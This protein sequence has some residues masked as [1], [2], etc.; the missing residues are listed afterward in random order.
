M[1][2]LVYSFSFDSLVNPPQMAMHCANA[3]KPLKTDGA[4]V[5][6]QAQVDVLMVLEIFCCSKSFAT[7]LALERPL[8]IACVFLVVVPFIF[9]F[10]AKPSAFLTLHIVMHL[11]Y[12]Y[13]QK[14]KI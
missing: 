13:L 10:I 3:A 11:L 7:L 2:K 14:D 4:L 8:I 5:R 6:L 9:I 12:V 1:L